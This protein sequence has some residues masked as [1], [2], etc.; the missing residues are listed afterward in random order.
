MHP[1]DPA[2]CLFYA[3]AHFRKLTDKKKIPIAHGSKVPKAE[4]N[5]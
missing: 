3:R 4:S 1:V 2:A 5:P